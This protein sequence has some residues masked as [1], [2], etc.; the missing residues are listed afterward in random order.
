[1]TDMR[2]S[3]GARDRAWKAER[4]RSNPAFY[5]TGV[6]PQGK[7]YQPNGQREVARRARQIAAGQL[8]VSP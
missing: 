1:M 2:L 6:S 7:Q 3:K 5:R 8:Q 4:L